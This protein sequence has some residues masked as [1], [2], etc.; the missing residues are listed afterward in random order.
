MDSTCRVIMEKWVVPLRSQILVWM[1]MILRHRLML[2][3]QDILFQENLDPLVREKLLH[4]LASV[5]SQACLS[6]C[7]ALSWPLTL[8]RKKNLDLSYSVSPFERILNPC[9]TGPPW[10]CFTKYCLCLLSCIWERK[11]Q[12]FLSLSIS[13]KASVSVDSTVETVGGAASLWFGFWCLRSRL[14]LLGGLEL[15]WKTQK[16]WLELRYG[17]LCSGICLPSCFCLL[18]IDPIH[19]LLERGGILLPL[20]TLPCARHCVRAFDAPHQLFLSHPPKLP[21][22]LPFRSYHRTDLLRSS[23]PFPIRQNGSFQSRLSRWEVSGFHPISC[24]LDDG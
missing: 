7:F 8:K 1:Q 4:A 17:S 10:I 13:P 23:K 16:L 20:A 2:R 3:D 9:L 14:T 22:N 6:A 15:S 12:C 24:G 18:A 21:V 11:V 5:A 19:T